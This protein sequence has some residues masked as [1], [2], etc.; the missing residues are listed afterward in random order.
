[1]YSYRQNETATF[2]L[3][4]SSCRFIDKV[5]QQHRKFSWS[6]CRIVDTAQGFCFVASSCYQRPGI[7]S[8]QKNCILHKNIVWCNS[9]Y[10]MCLGYAWKNYNSD[11]DDRINAFLCLLSLT[12]GCKVNYKHQHLSVINIDTCLTEWWP[13]HAV[14][15]CKCVWHEKPSSRNLMYD[16]HGNQVLTVLAE[17]FSMTL[18]FCACG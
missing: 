15:V 7:A 18:C 10:P 5:R 1:M 12:L 17:P 16:Y 11:R 8:M 13:T 9:S 4:V 3:T 2:K 14:S 6:W